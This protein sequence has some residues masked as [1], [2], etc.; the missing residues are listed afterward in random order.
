MTNQQKIKNLFKAM[1]YMQSSKCFKYVRIYTVCTKLL[2]NITGHHS[3]IHCRQFTLRLQNP[4]K[5][6]R[7]VQYIF[8]T[9][10]NIAIKCDTL[11]VV[12]TTI[13]IAKLIYIRN[14]VLSKTSHKMC[15]SFQY[16]NEDFLKRVLKDTII[17][18]VK[19]KSL[20]LHNTM[21]G[22]FLRQGRNNFFKSCTR[23]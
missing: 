8:M 18:I 11:S 3:R 1:F 22:P 23:I 14:F 5:G 4:T 20:Q 7:T 10:E 15:P 2:L 13:V 9:D 21:S 12:Y 19:N 6:S 16:R 17:P